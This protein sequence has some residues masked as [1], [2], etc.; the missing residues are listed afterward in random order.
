M[1]L[2][3]IAGVALTGSPSAPTATAFRLAATF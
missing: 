2:G 3:P 1:P